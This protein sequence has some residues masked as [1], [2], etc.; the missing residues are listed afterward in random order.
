MHPIIPKIT[1]F[2]AIIGLTACSTGTPGE[3]D[4]PGP[5]PSQTYETILDT[6]DVTSTLAG[7]TRRIKPGVGGYTEVAHVSGTLKHDTRAVSLSDSDG[8]TVLSGTVSDLQTGVPSN[9][10]EYVT[11]YFNWYSNNG[12]SYQMY[13][14]IGIVTATADIPTAGTAT[15]TGEA[16]GTLRNNFTHQNLDNGTSTV[17]ANFQSG[18]VNVVMTGFDPELNTVVDRVTVTGM[19]I[20]SNGFSGGVLLTS[21]NGTEID[22]IGANS[23]E[24]Y[25][26]YFYGYDINNSIPD[27]VG[28]VI[29]AEGDGT[30]IAGGDIHI[31]F[32]A[33]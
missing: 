8:L 11:K 16:N 10:Y 24:E 9:T 19:D 27:E 2:A 20:N 17:T 30:G 7:V 26:G 25:A 12:D 29:W 31:V 15:Y 14:V 33:D 4:G 21:L 18:K 23:T 32:M 13:G 3:D 1:V 5:D 6:T 28:G 22:I